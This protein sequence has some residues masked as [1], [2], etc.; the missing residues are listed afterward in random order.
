MAHSN[1]PMHSV[2]EKMAQ[3]PLKKRLDLSLSSSLERAVK[4]SVDFGSGSSSSSGAGVLGS[5]GGGAGNHLDDGLGD[6]RQNDYLELEVMISAKMK[7]LEAIS[8]PLLSSS[9]NSNSSSSGS[10]P[11]PSHIAVPPPPTERAT[12]Q[13]RAGSRQSSARSSPS[14]GQLPSSASI[15]PSGTNGAVAEAGVILQQVGEGGGLEYFF[16]TSRTREV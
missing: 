6:L 11:P 9:T 3:S 15:S 13:P 2:I 12:K 8:S 14:P 4:G 1:D 16:L 5:G 10:T 7:E